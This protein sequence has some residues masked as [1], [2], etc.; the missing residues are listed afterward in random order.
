MSAI[1]T[2]AFK[3]DRLTWL[4][5]AML[6]G[7]SYQ[8][9]I[10][11][12]LMP[13]LRESLDM[14]YTL[15]GV[16]STAVAS[17]MILSGLISDRVARRIGRRALFWT[18]GVG[19]V[20][21]SC[22]IALSPTFPIA[23]AAVLFNAVASSFAITA[24]NATLADRHGSMRTRAISE[25]NVA[26]ALSSSL[27]PL[28]IGVFQSAGLGWQWAL[29]ATFFIIMAIA[30]AFGSVPIPNGA[31]AQTTA[32]QP[33]QAS[34]PAAFWLY[35]L[36]AICVVAFEWCFVVWGADYLADVVGFEASL[37]S[38]TMGAYLG[39]VVLGRAA[40]S[41]LARWW[42]ARRLLVGALA[43]AM[44]A[45]PLFWLAPSPPL[46][47]LGL[48][49]AGLGVANLFPL[50]FSIAIGQSGGLTNQATARISLAVG[51]AIFAAPLIL[52]A[53]ADRF[54]LQEAYAIVPVIGAM[55]AGL[56]SIAYRQRWR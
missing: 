29:Y 1:A 56:L 36:V 22:A 49:V 3:R 31:P 30:L 8:Q 14:S 27:A 2:T 33:V 10:L 39:G 46:A 34:L 44:A 18:G 5:Y 6:A 15:G 37:A 20:I 32:D 17:G 24:V 13:F 9:G 50:T 35:W 21:G 25:A 23:F 45:F 38:T 55:T 41:V 7:V 47:V 11:G 52:G 28:L 4:M 19:Y 26:A 40:G 42:S 16:L 53:L 48:F 12:P 43:L 51:I 54:S